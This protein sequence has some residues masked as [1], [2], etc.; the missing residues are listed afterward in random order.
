M[1]EQSGSE[2]EGVR[3]APELGVCILTYN[4]RQVI[5]DCLESLA[6]SLAGT[7]CAVVVVDNHSTDGTP[8]IVRCLFP[9]VDVLETG[10]NLGYARG[11]NAGAAF[12]AD[13]YHVASVLFLNPDVQVSRETIPALR[14]ALD[15]SPYA[16]CAAG[17]ARLNGVRSVEAFRRRPGPLPKLL[18]PGVLRYLPLC[19]R[20]LRPVIEQFERGYYI[21]LDGLASGTPVY[22]FSGACF[23]VDAQAFQ[24]TGGFDPSTFLFQ[25]E[26]ILS[27]RLHAAGYRVVAA[28]DAE[29]AHLGGHSVSRRPVGSFRHFV[30]SEQH[31]L[32]RYYHWPWPARLG[33][34]LYRFCELALFAT[35]VTSARALHPKAHTTGGHVTADA[36]HGSNRPHAA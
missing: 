16:A 20:L 29:Y 32:R 19:A 11:N 12:L 30:H 7:D 24:A 18:V 27:E 28:P 2:E 22:T 36:V 5:K 6:R 8:A 25:E 34:L 9:E 13:R 26:L 21:P 33:F 17:V 4:S 15:S 31:L 35:Y 14:R 10:A 3:P 23:L 1:M